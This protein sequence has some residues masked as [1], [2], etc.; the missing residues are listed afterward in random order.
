[1]EKEL[2]PKESETIAARRAVRI[3]EKIRNAQARLLTK[4]VWWSNVT[5][6]ISGLILLFAF[7]FYL[8]FL[9]FG[10]KLVE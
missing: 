4:K 6:E 7:N 10:T 1:M 8:L 9:F 3:A 2:V 5:S